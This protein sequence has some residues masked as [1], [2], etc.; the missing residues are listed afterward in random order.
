MNDDCLTLGGTDTG[1][2]A[3]DATLTAEGRSLRASSEPTRSPVF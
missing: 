2:P 3:D 1:E